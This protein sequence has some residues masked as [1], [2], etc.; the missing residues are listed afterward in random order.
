M[1][2][3]VSDLSLRRPTFDPRPIHVEICST[4]RGT[5]RCSPFPLVLRLSP[6]SATYLSNHISLVLFCIIVC[7]CVVCIWLYVMYV[8]VSFCKLSILMV[9]FM[10]S[11]CY[12]CSVLGI[13]LFC[14]SVYC[15]CVNVYCT[16]AT[17]CQS[18]C[19]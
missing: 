13:A 12:V 11:Y 16:A 18:N 3:L 6:V 17:W 8:S 4:E 5:G 7:V 15:L 1:V 10:H 9:M 19:N 2:Q 14:R